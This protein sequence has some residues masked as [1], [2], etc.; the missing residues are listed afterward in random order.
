MG[1]FGQFYNGAIYGQKSKSETTFLTKSNMQNK[2]GQHK[3]SEKCL[4][5]EILKWAVSAKSIFWP[6][7]GQNLHLR[8]FLKLNLVCRQTTLDK[9]NFLRNASF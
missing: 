1:R 4:F 7:I 9:I 8:Q 5:L 3:F 2:F 6:S